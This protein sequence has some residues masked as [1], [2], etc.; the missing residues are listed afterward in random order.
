MNAPLQLLRQ[1]LIEASRDANSNDLVDPLWALAATCK[2][3]H[4][5]L[6]TQWEQLC[7]DQLINV[8]ERQREGGKKRSTLGIRL[9]GRH[10]HQWFADG[11]PDLTDRLLHAMSGAGYIQ[12]LTARAAEP[13][14]NREAVAMLVSTTISLGRNLKP[15]AQLGSV[16]E[17]FVRA[18][19]MMVEQLLT[20]PATASTRTTKVA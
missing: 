3:R 12:G 16:F 17:A 10:D 14:E 18:N 20:A 2:E 19:P 15:S 5:D 7:I 9:Q 4:I 8:I 6:L 1:Q 13:D 11:L